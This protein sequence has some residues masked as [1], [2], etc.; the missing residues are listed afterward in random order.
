[1]RKIE[2]SISFLRRRSSSIFFKEN[3]TFLRIVQTGKS[4]TEFAICLD[5]KVKHFSSDNSRDMFDINIKGFRSFHIERFS[6]KG[7]DKLI[8]LII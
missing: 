5:T 3:E 7:K 4:L 1:M 6:V 2:V 8:A